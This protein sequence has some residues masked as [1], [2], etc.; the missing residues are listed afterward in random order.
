[1]TR[2]AISPRFAIRTR[3]MDGP[4]DSSLSCR[5]RFRGSFSVCEEAVRDAVRADGRGLG[6]F[7]S[8]DMEYFTAFGFFK[9]AKR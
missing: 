8:E 1:M 4:P 3:L 6:A 5:K 9:I 7:I 2:Q